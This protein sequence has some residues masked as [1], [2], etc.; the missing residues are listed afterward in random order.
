GGFCPGFGDCGVSGMPA[1]GAGAS[2]ITGASKAMRGEQEEKFIIEERN[3]GNRSFEIFIAIISSILQNPLNSIKLLP[4]LT[5]S[6]IP[7]LFKHPVKI[8]NIIKTAGI[9]NFSNT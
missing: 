8:C 9:C 5:W 6:G 1:E 3:T 2:V 4:I 7:T